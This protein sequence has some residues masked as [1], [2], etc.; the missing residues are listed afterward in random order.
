[1]TR[2]ILLLT[3]CLLTVTLHAHADPVD[4]EAARQKA[5]AF[6]QGQMA[7]GARRRAPSARQLTIAAAGPADSYYIFN[8]K[9]GQGYVVVSG[10]D[11]TEDILG[12]SNT[13]TIDTTFMPCGM[14]MLLDN[15][16]DQIKFLRDH[17]ITREQNKSAREAQGKSFHLDKSRLAKYDQGKPYNNLCPSNTVTGCAATAMAELM[18]YYQWPSQTTCAIPGYVNN[19]ITIE[20][21]PVNSTID[22]S[23]I[24]K[25]YNTYWWVDAF[26]LFPHELWDTSEQADAIAKLMKYAGTSVHMEYGEESSAYDVCIPYALKRYF[27]YEQATLYRRSSFTNDDGQWNIMLCNE[28]ENNGPVLYF[29]SGGNGGHFFML[30]GYDYDG[31]YYYDVNFGWDGRKNDKFLLTVIKGEF[32]YK[33]NQSAVLGVTPQSVLSTT[34]IPLNLVTTTLRATDTFLYL[35]SIETNKFE[36]VKLFIGLLNYSPVDTYFDHGIRLVPA[37]GVNQTSIDIGIGENMKMMFYGRNG[38]NGENIDP[39][40]EDYKEGLEYTFDVSNE[41]KDGLYIVE[42]IS[43]EN[44]TATWL[45]NNY[46]Q[47]VEP[48]AT[49]VCNNKLAFLS[50]SEDKSELEL[51]GLTLSNSPALR[52]G[53]SS[54]LIY[55]IENHNSIWYYGDYFFVVAEWKENNVM[56][57]MPIIIVERQVLAG[58]ILLSSFDFTPPASGNIDI[59]FYKKNGNMIGRQTVNVL[60]SSTSLDMLEVTEMTLSDGDM[61]RGL[62]DGTTL[63]GTLYIKNNDI[64]QKKDDIIIGLEDVESP[65]ANRTKHVAVTIAPNTTVGYNFS[66]SNLTAGHHYVITASYASGEEFYRSQELLCTTDGMGEVEPGNEALV[67]F[68]YWFDD[69]YAN[70]KKASMSG[71]KAVVRASI[72]TDH[73]QNG[74]HFLHFRVQSNNNKYDWS[75]VSTSP[76]LKL[77]MRGTEA[78]LDYWIDDD[79]TTHVSLPLDENEDEHLLTFDLSDCEVGLHQICFQVTLLGSLPSAVQRTA[80]MKLPMGAIPQ[81][82]YWFDDDIAHSQ[83]FDGRTAASGDGYIYVNTL[84]MSNLSVGPHRL[85]FRTIDSNG[86]KRSAIM[87]VNVMKLPLGKGTGLEYWYDDDEAHSVTLDGVSEDDCLVYES[88]LNMSSLSVGLHRLT[89]RAI[90]KDGQLKSAPVTCYVMKNVTGSISQLEYWFDYDR[91][92]V[93]TLSGNEAVLGNKGAIFKGELDISGLRPG[94]HRLHY[95]GIGSDGQLSTATSSASILVKIDSHGDAVMASYSISVD[96]DDFIAQGL[97]DAKAEVDFSYVLNAKDLGKGIHTLQTTFWNSYGMSVSETTSFE[98]TYGDDDAI[99]TPQADEDEDGPIYNLS[100]MR[101]NS[102]AKGILIKNGKKYLV[103]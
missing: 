93:H 18:Y 35:R 44:G 7:K 99:N 73:L 11:A 101:V 33:D 30:E 6:L 56:K 5:A 81:L 32:H 2:H 28:L 12:Y 46:A 67:A 13:G 14:R 82:E 72:N 24:L 76:F 21:I 25:Q 88:Q 50:N 3:I 52:K 4:V 79:Y 83:T 29:G 78:R 55:M 17:G 40:A 16:A 62:I 60:P 77:G 65:Q 71:N 85:N 51:K 42:G 20:A 68:E 70:R 86:L 97:L 36:D 96:G 59:V 103:K 63:R 66:F 102:N 90:S 87:T 34:D 31:D 19:N 45:T 26:D 41:V 64:V 8:A 53:Q 61:E 94:H 54:E 100:G 75:G 38:N 91:N 10:E 9:D 39:D 98:V 47:G 57:K 80:V 27:G 49:L 58:D 1:M 37:D 69:D 48:F 84:N 95:R 15:Y 74:L 23:N 22:W 89:F 43:R 92:N